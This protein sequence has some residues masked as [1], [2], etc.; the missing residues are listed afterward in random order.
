MN[1]ENASFLLGGIFF[2]FLVGFSVAYFVY[3]T[4]PGAGIPSASIQAPVNASDPMGA[5]MG[6]APPGGMPGGGQADQQPSATMQQVQQ[7]IAALRQAI[8]RNPKDA[9]ALGRLG[10]LFYDAG[11]FDK[12]KDYYLQS[13]QI[14]PNNPNISTDLGICYQR[15]GQ[16][17]EAIRQFRSS[18]KIDPRHWQS[19]LN[20]GIVSLFDKH[21]VKT[22]EEAFA[23]VQELNP[24]FQGL[25]QIQQELQK[26][27]A[28]GNAR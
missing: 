22:A 2:G 1:R 9:K 10:D 24:T 27:K 28:G 26:I 12:A 5:G 8:E 19:W 4:A 3:H 13:L 25:P 11:M 15:L 17:D 14:E 16:P 18:L 21:D 20:L 7:E 6:E 23:K